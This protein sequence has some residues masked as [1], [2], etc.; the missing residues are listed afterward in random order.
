MAGASAVIPYIP[1]ALSVAGALTASEGQREAGQ[2]S[3]VAAERAA[4]AKRFEA[5]QARV[6][7]GQEIAAAQRAALEAKRQGTLIQSRQIALAAASG[8]GAADPTVVNLIARTAQESSYR[9]A[10]AL[11]GGEEKA[12]QLRMLAAG[13]DYEAS[14]A[15]EAGERQQGAYNT[16]ARASLLGTAGSLFAK[17]G[18]GGPKASGDSA[19][20]DSG[21]LDYGGLPTAGAN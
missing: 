8:A 5:A 14:M 21:G 16:A 11:Y 3:R 6:N 9:A 12:R 7:A 20:V 15:L 17:Y 13:R 10:V 4:A 1:A 19:A 2:G 18:M